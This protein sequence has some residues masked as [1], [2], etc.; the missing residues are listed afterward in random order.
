M[1]RNCSHCGFAHAEN[2]LRCG[3]CKSLLQV[4]P[5]SQEETTA[6][7]NSLLKGSRLVILL[8]VFV[9]AFFA[10][11][12]MFDNSSA[13]LPSSK[14]PESNTSSSNTAAIDLSRQTSEIEKTEAAR[15]RV[16]EAEYYKQKRARKKAQAEDPKDIFGNPEPRGC[17]TYIKDNGETT[18]NGNC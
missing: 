7:A 15:K 5:R 16:Q 2:A 17:E 9:I 3:N 13:V 18:S 14:I 8:V 10:I 12:K 6:A 1:N 11:Y 4:A